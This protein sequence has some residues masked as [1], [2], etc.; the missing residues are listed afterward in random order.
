[1]LILRA[2]N[3]SNQ[4]GLVHGFFGR[5]G[6][7]STGLY[8]SLNCG[9]SRLSGEKDRRENVLENRRRATRALSGDERVDLVT[10]SQIHSPNVIAVTRPWSLDESPQ[11]D[12]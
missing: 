8:E 9:P 12:A 11:G 10:L 1:M 5:T 7:V 6:G 4:A 2:E 3:L